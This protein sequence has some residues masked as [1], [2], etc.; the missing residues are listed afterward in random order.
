MK[1]LLAAALIILLPAMAIAQKAEISFHIRNGVLFNKGDMEST[2]GN[3]IITNVRNTFTQSI[4]GNYH[5][6][7][8]KAFWLNLG[9][10]IGYEYYKTNVP[11]PFEDYGYV[12]DPILSSHYT[13]EAYIPFGNIQAGVGYRVKQIKRIQ[14]EVRIG[15]VLHLPIKQTKVDAYSIARPVN[16]HRGNNFVLTGWYGNAPLG[17]SS[18]E[19][20]TMAYI[21]AGIASKMKNVSK[22]NL[23]LQLQ[24]ELFG[25]HD[26]N[27]LSGTYNDG[28]NVMRSADVFNGTHTSAS[29]VVGLVL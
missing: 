18:V 2:Y 9:I 17:S 27:Y 15:Q 13:Q 26:N 1:K 24:R 5:R 4:G 14:P 12:K 20:I 25:K 23:G 22:V 16:G 29:L 10:D 8:K 6:H 21:G 3:R 11:Y 7:L 28:A 19:F